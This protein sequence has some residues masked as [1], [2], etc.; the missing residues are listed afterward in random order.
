MLGGIVEIWILSLV[1]IVLPLTYRVLRLFF[2]FLFQICALFCCYFIIYS[3]ASN[4]VLQPL[5]RLGATVTGVDAVEK[6][7][8]I[9]QL[10]AVCLLY[11]LNIWD[12]SVL[13]Y[14][15]LIRLLYSV[16][17]RKQ[18]PTLV[19]Y[20]HYLLDNLLSPVNRV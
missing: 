5:A 3:R 15:K 20:F 9:A 17:W 7:I 1:H 8:K 11:I 12:L 16:Y 2:C 10:H 6:N 14:N 13:S 18:L 4:F 19:N